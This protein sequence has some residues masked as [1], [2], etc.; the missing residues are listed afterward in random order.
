MTGPKAKTIVPK[1]EL[2]YWLIFAEG[3]A[4]KV[5]E[6]TER[7]LE[8]E[9]NDYE[10]E[11]LDMKF[12]PKYRL[13]TKRTFT[14]TKDLTIPEELSKKLVELEDAENT[15]V[16]LV[17]TLNYDV[18]TGEAAPATARKAKK[19]TGVLNLDPISDGDVLQLSGTVAL[20]S[21]WEAG[22]F[23]ETTKAFSS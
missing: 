15:P 11:Y 12:P 8:A 7:A 10:P 1:Y 16:T 22:T 4:M 19:A 3:G 5:E 13:S 17:R 2:Q 9:A 21:D 6:T 14:F 20:T 23:N 18:V